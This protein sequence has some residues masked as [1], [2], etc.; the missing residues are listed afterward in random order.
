MSQTVISGG[1]D[2]FLHLLFFVFLHYLPTQQHGF[3]HHLAGVQD[4]KPGRYLFE[5]IWPLHRAYYH[6]HKVR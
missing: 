1:M 4:F 2:L 3:Q 5:Y 6:L